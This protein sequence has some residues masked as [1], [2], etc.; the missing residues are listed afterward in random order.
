MNQGLDGGHELAGPLPDRFMRRPFIDNLGPRGDKGTI[1]PPR[2]NRQER[3]VITETI[4]NVQTQLAAMKQQLN[5]SLDLNESFQKGALTIVPEAGKPKPT[6][7]SYIR[8]QPRPED[9]DV[10]DQVGQ[11]LSTSRFQTVPETSVQGLDSLGNKSLAYS[12]TYMPEENAR[13]ELNETV[14]NPVEQLD[15]GYHAGY[16]KAKYSS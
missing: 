9:I 4:S 7:V 12:S 10:S 1:Y 16:W 14:I 15:S 13:A 2:Q 11:Y 3:S 6:E 8:Y 5:F